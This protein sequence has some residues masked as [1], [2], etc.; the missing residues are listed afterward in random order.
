M[1]G[2]VLGITVLSWAHGRPVPQRPTRS[3]DLLV[4]SS[5][6]VKVIVQADARTLLSLARTY[7]GAATRRL[8]RGVALDLSRSDFDAMMRRP[9]V[10]H[11]SR[12]LPVAA[13]VL[14]TDS[15]PHPVRAA[16]PAGGHEPASE[17]RAGHG[18]GIGVAVIDSGI[19]PR[20][21]AGAEVVA[22][23]NLVAREATE[24]GDPFGHGT[25][26]ANTIVDA[27]V[28]DG[29]SPRPQWPPRLID[30][31]VLDRTGT[32][33][34]S[35]VLAGIDWAIANRERLGIRIVNLS[36]GHVVAESATTDPLGLAV[37]RATDAGLVVIASAGNHGITFTGAPVLGGI[38]S[39]ANS[40]AA[41]AVGALDAIERRGNALDA[42]APYSSRG[43]T[44]I[45]GAV[46]PDLAAPGTRLVR[47]ER[48]STD[49]LAARAGAR[50]YARVD[51]TSLAAASAAGGAARL[52]G[53]HPSLT[54][55]QVR[56]ALQT[57]ARFVTSAGLIGGGAG[58]VDVGAAL[59]FVAR[60]SDGAG[61]PDGISFVDQ[62]SLIDRLYDRTGLRALET[63]AAALRGAE[64]AV[65]GV[66]KLSGPANRLSQS[67]ANLLVWG[68]LATSS[69]SYYLSWGALL[70]NPRG[71]AVAW[72]VHAAPG[73]NGND[74]LTYLS[75]ARKTAPPARPS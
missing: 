42:V 57:G 70:R 69:R 18:T 55:W 46:K 17:V 49:S 1:L 59:R 25:L 50:E 65:V 39:P 52:L 20:Q 31:R 58:R 13:H 3:E 44:A 12:D 30:V 45:D 47:V 41:I 11:V 71:M 37:A 61:R 34:T 53:V 40:P 14:M 24:R 43:P 62:G 35:D 10:A 48:T 66:L 7:P 2:I 8:D 22:R 60:P 72:G 68:S 73:R 33:S 23:V 26:V 5:E 4:V 32:G 75:A 15:Q 29:S 36:L 64:H 38:A 74:G 63:G 27:S 28:A 9:A 16:F 67:P 6:R 19:D 56:L 21:V 51:G 54:P